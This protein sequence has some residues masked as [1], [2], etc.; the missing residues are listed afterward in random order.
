MTEKVRY[1]FRSNYHGDVSKYNITLTKNA[2]WG[3]DIS[4]KDKIEGL[5]PKYRNEKVLKIKDS[6]NGLIVD[7]EGH[8]IELN[9]CEESYLLAA[10]WARAM[11]YGSD[12]SLI[13][14]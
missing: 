11:E 3:S 5:Y 2:N 6:G 10:L 12:L 1:K 14:K 8:V 13:K 7:M 9:Y 4:L